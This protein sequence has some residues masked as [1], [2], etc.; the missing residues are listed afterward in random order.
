MP[1]TEP[2]MSAE[3]TTERVD[4]YADRIAISG[5]SR[6]V[7]SNDH[8][9]LD[10]IFDTEFKPTGTIRAGWIKL[11]YVTDS[12]DEEETNTRIIKFHQDSEERE[13]EDLRQRINES[14]AQE[15][16]A[17]NSP[18]LTAEGNSRVVELYNNRIMIK[19][20]KGQMFEPNY[21]D[22]KE[23]RLENITGIELGQAYIQ[24]GQHGYDEA[25]DYFFRSIDH[26]T[27]ENTV[28]FHPKKRHMFQNLK[29]QINELLDESQKAHHEEPEP[30][31]P[32]IDPAIQILRKQFATGE[33]SAEEYKQR[34]D[35]LQETEDMTDA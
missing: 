23:I 34:L 16:G 22:K 30:T 35:L 2:T 7:N 19:V 11:F 31:D 33:I 6:W 14:L 21:P 18:I 3:G 17:D 1:D 9:L 27:D 24:F 26:A 10:T 4:L 20:K 28:G 13:F 12:A 32:G 5:T 25:N 8:I 29:T 15:S